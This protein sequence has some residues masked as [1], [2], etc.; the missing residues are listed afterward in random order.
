MVEEKLFVDEKRI[1]VLIGSHGD[2]K[3]LLEKEL[4]CKLDINSKSGEVSINAED[5]GEV[6]LAKN[7]IMAINVGH[8]PQK[9]LALKEEDIG[10]DIVDVKQMV[11]EAKRLKSVMGRLIG[12]NG[13]TRKAIEEVTGCSVAINSHAISVIGPYEAIMTIHE[14]VEMLIS[15]A[16]HKSFYSFLERNASQKTQSSLL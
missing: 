4:N 3:A 7:V 5:G 9:A 13:A 16:S 15:G 6:F 10:I 8:T 1:P 11:H 2:D 14:A 12:K